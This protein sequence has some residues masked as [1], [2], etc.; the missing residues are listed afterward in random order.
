MQ[1]VRELRLCIHKNTGYLICRRIDKAQILTDI[2][3]MLAQ[4]RIAYCDERWKGRQMLHF[5]FR[6]FSEIEEC[7]CP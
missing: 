5:L 2:I 6:I 7:S 4:L 1:Q 3:V